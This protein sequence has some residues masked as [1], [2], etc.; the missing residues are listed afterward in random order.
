VLRA[1]VA[2]GVAQPSAALPRRWLRREDD[3]V[4]RRLRG[5]LERRAHVDVDVEAE[6]RERGGDNVSAAAVA[7]FAQPKLR[8]VHGSG[9]AASD[10]YELVMLVDGREPGDDRRGPLARRVGAGVLYSV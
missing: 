4:A 1:S 2:S 9:T 5:G 6:V 3:H 8:L 7:V 10:V